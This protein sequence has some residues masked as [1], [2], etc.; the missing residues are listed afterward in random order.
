MAH[1]AAAPRRYDRQTWLI[2]Q[3]AKKSSRRA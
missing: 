3:I 2:L 1:R